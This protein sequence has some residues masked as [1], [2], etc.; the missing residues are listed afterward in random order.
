MIGARCSE[1][2]GAHIEYE[3]G[4]ANFINTPVRVQCVR[5]Y[6]IEACSE[7][8]VCTAAVRENGPKRVVRGLSWGLQ[9]VHK[10]GTY[11]SY[12]LILD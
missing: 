4:A 1:R 9:C 8:G 11:L 12:G 2:I 6:T 3:R 10:G 5:N 7:G